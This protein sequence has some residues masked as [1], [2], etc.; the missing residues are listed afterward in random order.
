MVTR[1]HSDVPLTY[2]EYAC[3]PN[4]GRRYELI[5][6]DLHVLPAPST[7]H[8]RV[9]RRL[10][11][12]LMQQLEERGIAEIFNAPTDV[13]LS[14]SNIVQPDLILV[15]MSREGA[16]SQRGI[17]GAPNV[18]VEIVS[19]SNRSDDELL[20][21]ALYAKW[22]IPEYWVVD[23]EHAQISVYRAEGG[24]YRHVARFDRASILNSIEFPEVSVP[25]EKV[26]APFPSSR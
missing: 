22:G 5:E 3:L 25:L 11:F 9:S 6:G 19:P 10:Q 17:E 24:A 4:D 16:V 13:I 15:R 1:F 26:F 7:L 21:K 14:E 20:K 18:A 23:P 8:Q 12:L 2:R